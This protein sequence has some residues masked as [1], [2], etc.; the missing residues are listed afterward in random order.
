M[1][2]SPE[3]LTEMIE[4]LSLYLNR[5]E[6]QLGE[7]CGSIDPQHFEEYRHSHLDAI[8]R[9][10]QDTNEINIPIYLRARYDIIL[11]QITLL[12]DITQR[13]RNASELNKRSPLEKLEAAWP[14]NFFLSCTISNKL[15]KNESLSISL[16][17]LLDKSLGTIEKSAQINFCVDLPWLLDHYKA[18][19][20]YGT[21]L[22]LIYGAE[23]IGIETTKLHKFSFLTACYVKPEG[24]GLNH[25]KI[26]LFAYDDG[27]MRVV[28]STANLIAIDWDDNTQGL[29]ISP[30]LPRLKNKE[31]KNSGESPTGFRQDLI[32]YLS[33]YKV[34]ELNYWINRLQNSDCSSVNVC[35]V[36]SIPGV[37]TANDTRYGHLR[38]GKLLSKHVEN[39]KSTDTIVAQSPSVGKF[40]PTPNDWAGGEFLTSASACRQADGEKVHQ[41]RNRPDKPDFRFVF[42]T[43]ENVKNGY[44]GFEFACRFTMC[45]YEMY[46][47]Q[48]WIQNILCQWV[49]DKRHRSRCMPHIKTYCRVAGSALAE[50]PEGL[51]WFLLTSANMSKNAWGSMPYYRKNTFQ[52]GSYEIGVLFLPK[53]VLGTDLLPLTD[54]KEGPAFPMPYDLPLVPYGDSDQM[55]FTDIERPLAQQFQENDRIENG[56]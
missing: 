47:E 48:K 54:S 56:H 52:I 53:F 41:D 39:A 22:L 27:S 15:A 16:L 1:D 37:R 11:A 25:S 36:Y 43:E 38:L 8:I 50:K 55:F 28:I 32:D 21:P 10:Y 49:S 17:E 35:L 40:G 7:L 12:R 19:Q 2:I 34:S 9:D 20:A 5:R 42:A 23:D 33:C 30:K 44:G 13:D 31:N 18:A 4:G 26:S 3:T 51:R 46:I 24:I 29:W 45:K 14:Y 6:C